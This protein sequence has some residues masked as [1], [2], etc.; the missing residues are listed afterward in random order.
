MKR[1]TT[2]VLCV[3]WLAA[4]VFLTGTPADACT[5]M[6]ITPGAS[7]DGSML[8]THSNDGELTDSSI[9][10]V[11]AKKWP[12]G[13]SRNVYASN[14]PIG[15]IP[16]YNVN[17]LQRLNVPE[18][19]PSYD[20]TN[21]ARSIPIITIPQVAETQ[22]YLDGDYGIMNEKGLMLGECSCPGPVELPPDKKHAFYSDELGRIALER[23]S[24]AREAVILIG[25]LIDK[26]G[27]YGSGE[28]LP[29]ADRNEAWV[30]EMTPLPDGTAVWA[31]QRVPD[32]TIFVAANEFR[33]R[34][35]DRNNK[36]QLFSANLD[37]QLQNYACLSFCSE[38][39]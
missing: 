34:D 10:Y 15:N 35:L 20:R 14:S 16:A 4:A 31:A 22:A 32:G 25:S 11:P 37:K 30:L 13:S 5:T 2:K 3:L 38:A 12:P 33:I 9:V 6:I 8:V 28:T 29:I 36:D 7:A 19:T 17:S 27:L 18:R 26:Y 23:C 21:T 24:T 39:G 1:G